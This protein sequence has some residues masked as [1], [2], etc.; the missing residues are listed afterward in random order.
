MGLTRSFDEAEVLARAAAAF[1]ST[2]FEG[3]SVDDLVAAT[4]L[5]RGSLYKAFGSK[6]GLFLAAL[7]AAETRDVLTDDD[8]DLL[9]VA[10]LDVAPTDDVARESCRT[11]LGRLPGGDPATTVGTRL[12]QRAGLAHPRTG[13]ARRTA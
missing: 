12:V 13:R 9:L 11:M 5:F 8:L 4:G 1:V 10:L 2:G 6:R 3:T 7:G